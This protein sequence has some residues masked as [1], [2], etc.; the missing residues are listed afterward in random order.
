MIFS[1]WPLKK[2]EPNMVVHRFQIPHWLDLD[3]LLCCMWS[4]Y[5]PYS[6]FPPFS[7]RTHMERVSIST[8]DTKWKRMRKKKKKRKMNESVMSMSINECYNQSTSHQKSI[9][10][11]HHSYY[12]SSQVILLFFDWFIPLVAIL[13]RMNVIFFLF[14]MRFALIEKWYY[15]FRFC[16][17]DWLIVRWQT[18]MVALYFIWNFSQLKS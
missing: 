7:F 4:L 13:R 6:V 17:F 10:C 9:K 11:L 2:K 5:F 1:N 16:E 12:S 14:R 18:M 3:E 8:L 15:V